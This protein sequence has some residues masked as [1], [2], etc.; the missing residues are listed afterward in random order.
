[1]VYN[2]NQEDIEKIKEMLMAIGRTNLMASSKEE[3]GK[4]IDRDL[5]KNSVSKLK[6]LSDFSVSSIFHELQYM[7]ANETDG[8]LFLEVILE[9]Y[10]RTA[11]YYKETLQSFLRSKSSQV[12]P[13]LYAMLDYIMLTDT[14]LE[15]DRDMSWDE[16]WADALKHKADLRI[17][18]LMALGVL[19]AYSGK[20]NAIADPLQVTRSFIMDYVSREDG[21]LST[22]EDYYQMLV[23]RPVNL[24]E[25]IASVAILYKFCKIVCMTFSVDLSREVIENSAEAKG[26]DINYLDSYSEKKQNDAPILWYNDKVDNEFWY[27]EFIGNAYYMI[28]CNTS[29]RTY[30][31]YTLFT[32]SE[33]GE[34]IGRVLNPKSIF[35]LLSGDHD[36]N[37]AVVSL[38]NECNRKG[39]AEKISFSLM[40]PVGIIDDW[41]KMLRRLTLRRMLP[42]HRYF[43]F[44]SKNFHRDNECWKLSDNFSNA[45]PGTSYVLSHSMYAVTQDYILVQD[46]ELNPENPLGF[47]LIPDKYYKVDRDWLDDDITL[48][49]DIGILIL[50]IDEPHKP[51]KKY[52]ALDYNCTYFS[53][54]DDEIQFPEDF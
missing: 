51:I 53:I 32:G 36:E 29:T 49:D 33:L 47:D 39:E 38:T 42:T 20:G 37:F 12:M 17:V 8:L 22:N 26:V 44:F 13:K 41:A 5:S 35:S 21:Y 3:F 18:V 7:V 31:K 25:R 10:E 19:P 23:N 28:R 43:D 46:I 27:F 15:E 24:D 16:Q 50:G 2:Y 14:P 1:M 9:R 45:Y 34:N 11:S 30:E 52:L 6:L 54:V 4:I 40:T 48:D